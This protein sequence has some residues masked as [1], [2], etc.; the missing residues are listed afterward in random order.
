MNRNYSRVG[1]ISN[2]IIDQLYFLQDVLNIQ[3]ECVN[4]FLKDILM[5]DFVIAYC[6]NQL[7]R[8]LEGVPVSSPVGDHS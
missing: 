4:S 3:V 1:E 8:S 7:I 2:N 5:K 6:F